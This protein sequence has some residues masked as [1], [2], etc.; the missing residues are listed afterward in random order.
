MKIIWDDEELRRLEY[1]EEIL[2]ENGRS[3]LLFDEE[4]PEKEYSITF[5]V[6]DPLIASY[7]LSS[8]L[9]SK[10]SED[11]GIG[12]KVTSIQLQDHNS[13]LREQLIAAIDSVLRR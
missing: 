1:G 12:I 5:K 7:L 11:T 6:T 9:Y 10:S 3:S 4:D 8:S 13:A 2:N